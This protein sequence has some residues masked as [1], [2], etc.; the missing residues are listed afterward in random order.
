MKGKNEKETEEILKFIE[1]IEHIKKQ[2]DSKAKTLE[3]I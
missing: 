3:D 2:V 1:D